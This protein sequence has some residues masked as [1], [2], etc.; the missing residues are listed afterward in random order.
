MEQLSLPTTPRFTTATSIIVELHRGNI[1]TML[2]GDLEAVE[3]GAE[4][5]LRYLREKYPGAEIHRVTVGRTY[6][7]ETDY[8]DGWIHA[9]RNITSEV[10]ETVQVALNDWCATGGV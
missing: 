7:F 6:A 10:K 2:P 8:I 1:D 4:Y 5:V 9:V 3:R